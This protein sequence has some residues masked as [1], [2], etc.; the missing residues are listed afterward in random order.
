MGKKARA[1]GVGRD[2]G[3]AAGGP[4]G[5]LPLISAAAR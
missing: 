3:P 5:G 2:L 1:G 4:E